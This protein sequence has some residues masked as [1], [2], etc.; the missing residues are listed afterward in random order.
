[1]GP[2]LS[3]A[4]WLRRALCA[5]VRIWELVLVGPFLM[6]VLHAAWSPHGAEVQ[7][8]A[9]RDYFQRTY[10]PGHHSEREEEWLIRDFFK[11]RRGGTFVDVGANHFRHGSK[12][13]YLE[14]FLGWSGV[15]IEPQGEFA[16][17]YVT[18]RPRT[19]FFP[20]FVSSQS[21]S[22]AKLYIPEG[23]PTVASGNEE[24]ANAF[25]TI[26][27]VRDVPTITLNDLLDRQGV[28]N[29]DLVTMDIELHEPEALAGFDVERFRPELVCVEALQPVRQ[30]ILD[31]FARHEY[32]IVGR[33]IWVDRENLYFEPLGSRH[34][35]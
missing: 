30:Q 11:D 19:R 28:R 5:R 9:E 3:N 1:M 21:D 18:E 6:L 20:Y 33:Y 35:R 4:R 23:N 10:G 17:A 12:T 16:A 8:E 14:R 22:T 25:G 7:S 13:Y 26:A 32:V 2:Q 15:A 31:Y 34:G 29:I 27:E 24:F